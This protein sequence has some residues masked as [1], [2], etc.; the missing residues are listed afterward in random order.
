MFVEIN[1]SFEMR[2]FLFAIILILLL[3]PAVSSDTMDN[4]AIEGEWVGQFELAGSSTFLRVHVKPT[5]SNVEAT[6]DIPQRGQRGLEVTNI[7]LDGEIHFEIRLDGR[8]YT[9]EGQRKDQ[10]TS[11]RVTSEGQSGTFELLRVAKVD[12]RTMARYV[13]T[14]RF[15]T[16]AIAY[17]GPGGG[18]I[19]YSSG[20]FRSLTALSDSVFFFG[21]AREISFPIESKI[22][23]FTGSGGQVS[24]LRIETEGFPPKF[25]RRFDV[26]SEEEVKFQN[27]TITLA[28][29]LLVPSS[30]GPHP[31][32]VFV[33]A[34]GDQTRRSVGPAPYFFA[35]HGVEV[36][37]YDKRGVAG[38]GGDWRDSTFND[39]AGDALAAV[40]LLKSRADI[41]KHHIGLWGISQGPWVAWLAAAQSHDIAFVIAVSGPAVTPAKQA[42]FTARNTLKDEG[43]GEHEINQ[44]LHFQL[45]LDEVMRGRKK[46]DVLAAEVR[47]VKDQRW[48]RFVEPPPPNDW[49]WKWWPK[50]MDY[51]PV[52]ILKRITQPM[53]AIYGGVDK[54][55]NV[56]ETMPILKNALDTGQNRDHLIRLFPNANHDLYEA[57]IETSK[58]YALLKGFVP[59]Y[60]DVMLEWLKR[61][62]MIIN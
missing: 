26:Y 5:S 60:F 22:E 9:F 27:G 35:V 1:W 57:D 42:L 52:P 36:L 2:S 47:R 51:E 28:G 58:R 17:V 56:R 15:D 6:C 38:S 44:A 40:E 33:H 29:T 50:V 46:M 49:S 16:G 25:A 7:K 10:V 53:L 30:P 45:L 3:V 41:D 20:L 23:F 19:D 31:A 18:Y 8:L 4:S 62:H 59:G 54:L 37:I 43:F 21:H 32:M 34:G 61:G 39:L 12:P 11:G 48:F 55:V 14:Y 13:G 24:G